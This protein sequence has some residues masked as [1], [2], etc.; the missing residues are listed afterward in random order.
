MNKKIDLVQ[1]LKDCPK[2]M[3]LDCAIFNGTVTFSRIVNDEQYPI[4]I[5]IDDDYKEYLNKY[6]SYVD[7]SFCKCVIFPKGKTTWEGFQKPFVDGDV[8]TDIEGAIIIYQEITT[9][10]YCGSFA[11]LDHRNQFIPHYKAYL[12][13]IRLSTEEEK[14]KLFQAIKDNGYRW[15]SK[16]KTLKELIVPK[17]KVG[18]SIQSKTDNNDKFTITNI[19]NN[20]FYYGC[21]NN[22]EFMIPVIK[23]DNWEL[24]TNKTIKDMEEKKI[25]QMSLANCDLDKV[26]NEEYCGVLGYKIDDV[27]FTNDTGWIRITKKLWDCY[28]KEHVYEGICIIN[29]HEYKDI[30]HNNVT[31]KIQLGHL[32]HCKDVDD[33]RYVNSITGDIMI[34]QITNKVSVIKFKPDVCDN[35]IE[36]QLGDYEIEVR[37]GKTY[38]VKKKPKYPKTYDECCD[39]LNIPNDERY[40]DIDIPV[41]YNKLLSAFTELLICRDAYWKI[42]GEQM[43]LGKLWEPDW[44]KHDKK[45]IID[46]FKDT[47]IYFENETYDDNTILAFPT[48]EMRDAFFENFKDL[49][50][51]CKKLL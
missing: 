9:S 17:F 42:A 16:T 5:K 51:Q 27:I 13:C 46:V 1:I 32:K 35:Q 36:L 2:D 48:E 14:E 12:D 37:D 47:V 26:E 38:V 19:D 8:V 11:S 34:N 39:V 33:V 22:H 24:V 20:K 31:G 29:G 6:G 25:N 15:N 4:E 23:Q 21:G 41:G 30:R 45:Y 49:I 44:K 7:R 18:D 50:K 10:G 40:I 28:A 3:P 43:G